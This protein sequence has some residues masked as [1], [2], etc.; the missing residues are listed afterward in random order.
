VRGTLHEYGDAQ[1]ATS[2]C[3]CAGTAYPRLCPGL[4]RPAAHPASHHWA[5]CFRCQTAASLTRLGQP[6]APAQGATGHRRNGIWWHTRTIE[7]VS[8]RH[9]H[10]LL[11]R[12]A[13]RR[14]PLRE[15]QEPQATRASA[16]TRCSRRCVSAL[17]R[18]SGIEPYAACYVPCAHGSPLI[19]CRRGSSSSRLY[20]R[21]RRAWRRC[22]GAPASR[23][24]WLAIAAQAQ[25][26][27]GARALAARASAGAVWGIIT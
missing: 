16:L 7:P 2:V 24:A 12:N 25:P 23:S 4:S 5:L 17:S 10:R 18:R 27:V 8:W 22:D 14:S 15:S 1:S 9:R 11:P 3:A 20:R 19:P 13:T 6:S 26:R 21:A